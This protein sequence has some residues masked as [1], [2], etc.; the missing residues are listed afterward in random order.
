MKEQIEKYFANEK[1]IAQMK[2]DQC[3]LHRE[4]MGSNIIDRAIKFR[5]ELHTTENEILKKLS[6]FI[7][8]YQSLTIDFYDNF[9]LTSCNSK[10]F[11]I[12]MSYTDKSETFRQSITLP[13]DTDKDQEY[14]EEAKR[15][16]ITH[17]EEQAAE[18]KKKDIEHK[19]NLLLSLQKQ[20]EI[21]EAT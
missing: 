16:I 1:I 3:C 8:C 7:T 2:T 13:F 18:K 11:T 9:T 14:L 10:E 15:E 17:W 19:K 4:I 12:E 21:M 5:K 6:H 20:L